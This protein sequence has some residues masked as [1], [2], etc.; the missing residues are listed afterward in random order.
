M[1]NIEAFNPETD[2]PSDGIFS[3]PKFLYGLAIFFSLALMVICIDGYNALT[4]ENPLDFKININEGISANEFQYKIFE[5]AI[6]EDLKKGTSI[7]A[8]K[9]KFK[10]FYRIPNS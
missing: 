5:K 2:L 7:E 1:E 3:N 6:E 10:Y 9:L 4:Y 8:I